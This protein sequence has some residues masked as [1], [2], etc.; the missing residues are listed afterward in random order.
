[1]SNEHNTQEALSH[2]KS[3]ITEALDYAQYGQID[4][5]H[6]KTWVIDQ[7]VRALTGCPEVTASAID[8]R[9][10]PYTYT[11]QGESDAY[12][13]WVARYR[14]GED[15]PDTYTWDCGIAP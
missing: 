8:C 4:G 2:V 11:A 9:G 12:Q 7:M 1:M 10:N 13:R 5:D 14:D 15:G 6:H 3:R